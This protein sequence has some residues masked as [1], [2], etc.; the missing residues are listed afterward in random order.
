MSNPRPQLIFLS[1]HDPNDVGTWSG[2]AYSVYH[3]LL[4]AGASVE[5]VRANWTEGVARTAA[6]LLRK[7]GMEIDLRR[8][9]IYA[10]LASKEA[11][12]RL[13]FTKGN[14]I[15]A[16]AAAPYVF[17]LNTSRPLVFVSDATFASI[18]RIYSTFAGMPRWLSND[19]DKVEREAL[20]KSTHV[21]FSSEWAKSSAIVD[22]EVEPDAISVMPLGPNIRGEVIDR[23]KTAKSADFRRGVRLLFIGADWD[24]KGGPMVLDIKRE[25]D[26]RE[27]P[28]EL[29]LV[30]NCPKD[31]PIQHDIHVLGRLDKSDEGQLLELCRVYETAQFFVLPTSAEAYGIVFSEAQA[32]GCPSLTFAVGG[33]PTA[34]LDGIT[35][36]TLPLGAVAKDFAEKI[37]SLVREPRQY[38]RMSANCRS[39][40]ETEANWDSWAK[41]II[42]IADRLREKTRDSSIPQNG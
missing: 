13:G 3:G 17:S 7:I 40:Y 24:R 14:V 18:K 9:V 4:R 38:E 39:R 25:L 32:F 21:L 15:V 42:N 2:T 34:V 8:S 35:G 6:R 20:L 36:F 19:A 28:C 30:G 11:S 10:Y 37:C 33:T 12:L 5:I 29:F 31:L 1:P 22:Y 41:A 23:F 26:S 16:V 27:V